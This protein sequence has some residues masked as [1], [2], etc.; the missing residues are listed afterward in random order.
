MAVHSP[1]RFGKGTSDVFLHCAVI[2]FDHRICAYRRMN[3]GTCR[4]GAASQGTYSSKYLSLAN[5]FSQNS[6]K[7]SDALWST[8]EASPNNQLS[9]Q[10][11]PARH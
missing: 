7:T 10:P 2:Q 6:F 11:L 5:I 9:P 4:Q 1:A 3:A 8:P